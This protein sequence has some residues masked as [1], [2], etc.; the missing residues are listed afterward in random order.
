MSIDPIRRFASWFQEAHRAGIPLY[1]SAALATV[2][3]RGRPSVRFVLLK[4]FDR[5]GFVFFTNLRSRKGR[6]MTRN[7]YAALAVYWDKT[8]KQVR[9]EGPVRKINEAE[10]D[11]YWNSRPRA[12]NIAALASDQGALLDR[13]STLVS[14]FRRL[15]Q[16]YE[17]LPLPRP[18]HWTGFRIVP[19]SI[20]FWT[21]GEHRLHH[22]ELFTKQRGGWKRTLL[23][24]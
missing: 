2:D 7:P 11:A 23:Q 1:E 14:R 22:R 16:S 6:E 15:Y 17:G 20:E 13:R 3:L 5:H 24:P 8:G 10:A 21:R 9:I 12:H 18:K 4:K 19:G